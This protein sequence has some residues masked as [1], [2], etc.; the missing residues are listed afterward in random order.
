MLKVSQVKT[1]PKEMPTGITTLIIGAPKV[2][3]TTKGSEW[4]ENGH[5]GVLLID[6]D[7]GSDFVDG[8]QRVVVPFLNAPERQVKDKDGNIVLG[9]NKAPLVEVIPPIERG[10]V[11]RTGDLKGQPLEAYSLAEVVFDLMENW[12]SY[13]IDTV[14]LDTIDVVNGWIEDEIAP[15]G[16]FGETGFGADYAKATKRNIDIVL[17]LQ[18]LVKQKN[19]NLVLLSH[20]K[21][22][23]EVDGK[24]QLAPELPRGLAS[25]LCAKA[26][27]IGYVTINKKTGK[28]MI[29]FQGYDERS[30]G[31]RINALH[32]KECEFDYREVRKLI[33]GE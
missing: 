9:A 12:N 1:N 10:Y 11:H 21:K 27:I 15:S 17:K 23:V 8:C 28:H 20:A 2:G 18:N 4:S 24:M 29:S 32:G 14:V 3:K 25:K 5:A 13:N 16:N 19:A 6:A 22:T 31:S 26:D 30:V 33:V 7:L